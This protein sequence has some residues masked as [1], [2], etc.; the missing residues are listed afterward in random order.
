[1]S[2]CECLGTCPFFLD[3]MA[4]MPSMSEILKQRYCRAGWQ[5]CARHRIFTEFGRGAVPTDLFPNENEA[6]EE[7]IRELRA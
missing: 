2:D 4:N 7:L 5:T 1:M 3:K 6:A